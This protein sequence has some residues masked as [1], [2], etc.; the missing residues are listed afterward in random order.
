MGVV[1]KNNA[2]TK[3]KTVRSENFILL[4]SPVGADKSAYTRIMKLSIFK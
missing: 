4:A 2:K 3:K 1:A